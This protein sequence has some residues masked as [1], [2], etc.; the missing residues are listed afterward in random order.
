MSEIAGQ[1]VPR[2]GVRILVIWLVLC[3][4]AVPL[5]VFVLGDHLPPGRMSVEASDQTNANTVLMALLVPIAL[6]VVVY[7]V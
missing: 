6:L 2:H 4:I 7:F 1:R 3:V 5:I